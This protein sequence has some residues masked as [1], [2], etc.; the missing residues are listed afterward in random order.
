VN[1]KRV[2]SSTNIPSDILVVWDRFRSA[3]RAIVYDKIIGGGASQCIAE[4]CTELATSYQNNIVENFEERLLKY[5]YCKLQNI[6]MVNK[7]M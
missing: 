5:L 3:H 6:F 2:T 4:A 7:N 1:A